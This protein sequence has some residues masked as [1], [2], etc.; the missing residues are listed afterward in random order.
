MLIKVGD[1]VNAV[2]FYKSFTGTVKVIHEKYYLVAPD[3]GTYWTHAADE[4][5]CLLIPTSASR[6]YNS[7]NCCV[8]S[9]IKEAVTNA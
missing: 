9:I 1:R 2:N 3:N 6:S 8:K 7:N 5:E 4:G